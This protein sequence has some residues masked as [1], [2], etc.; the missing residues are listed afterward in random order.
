MGGTTFGETPF[1]AEPFGFGKV[2]AVGSIALPAFEVDADAKFVAASLSADLGIEPLDV[3]GLVKRE[4][5]G[6]GAL[7]LGIALTM[8]GSGSVLRVI[9]GDGVLD[10]P[11]FSADGAVNVRTPSEGSGAITLPAL[12]VDGATLQ[13]ALHDAQGV[14]DLPAVNVSAESERVVTGAGVVAIPV[15]VLAPAAA[16][17]REGSGAV[18]MPAVALDGAA[19]RASSGVGAL[20]LPALETTTTTDGSPE[21]VATGVI[22]QPAV[23]LAGAGKR[24]VSGTGLLTLATLALTIDSSATK[25]ATGALVLPVAVL[26]PNTANATEDGRQWYRVVDVKYVEGGSNMQVELEAVKRPVARR[27]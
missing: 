9:T 27:P 24:E 13:K 17:G 22:A 2:E 23:E 18:A 5:P 12:T 8:N 15:S 6:T 3:S 4:V 14:I 11:A 1:G 7:V 25:F 21:P 16:V 20:T 19:A 10:L 26:Y